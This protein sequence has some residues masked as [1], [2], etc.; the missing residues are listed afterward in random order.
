MKLRSLE[1]NCEESQKTKHQARN[2]QKQNQKTHQTL[3]TDGRPQN[4]TQPPSRQRPPILAKQTKESQARPRA[5]PQGADAHWA[6][7]QAHGEKNGAHPKPRKTAMQ[8]WDTLYREPGDQERACDQGSGNKQGGGNHPGSP[9]G[10]RDREK[11][12]GRSR[13]GGNRAEPGKG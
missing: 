5:R 12:P 11:G 2:R 7:G 6:K 4:E 13:R 8:I 9:G 3:G 10:E 1:R